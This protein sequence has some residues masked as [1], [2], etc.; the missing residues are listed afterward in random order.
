MVETKKGNT[1]LFI[2]ENPT[3]L[4]SII[5]EQEADLIRKKERL[6]QVVSEL[7]QRYNPQAKLPKIT[8]YEGID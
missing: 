8:F 6:S 5:Y 1:K 7:E 4:F 2:A 3:K